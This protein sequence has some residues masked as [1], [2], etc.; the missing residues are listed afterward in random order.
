MKR[1]QK[2]NFIK[3][4]LLTIMVISVIIYAYFNSYTSTLLDPLSSSS[5]SIIQKDTNKNYTGI[6]KEVI[7][8]QDGYCTISNQLLS[9]CNSPVRKM[10]ADT[11]QLH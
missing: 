4:L 3:I 9:S 6:G 2:K 7:E 11:F 1:K 10:W 8:G 5:Y